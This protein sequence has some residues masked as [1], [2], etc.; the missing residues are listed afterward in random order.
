MAC[1]SRKDICLYTGSFESLGIDMRCW[2][3]I[4][5]PAWHA[6]QVAVQ[7]QLLLQVLCV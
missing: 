6:R 5:N 1:K 3:S 2:Q 7:L 4:S